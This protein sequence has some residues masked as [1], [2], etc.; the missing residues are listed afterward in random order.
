MKYHEMGWKKRNNLFTKIYFSAPEPSSS[1]IYDLRL[2]NIEIKSCFLS[3]VDVIDHLSCLM[4][5]GILEGGGHVEHVAR[6]AMQHS[7]RLT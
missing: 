3:T 6:R 5:E 2:P 4:V 7:L 1:T